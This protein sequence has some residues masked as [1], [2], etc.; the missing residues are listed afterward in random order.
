MEA[1][2]SADAKP[3]DALVFFQ[4]QTS[5]MDREALLARVAEAAAKEADAVTKLGQLTCAARGAA[6]RR[7]RAPPAPR[8]PPARRAR[9]AAAPPPAPRARARAEADHA[10]VRVRS[11]KL[12]AKEK[13]MDDL[14]AGLVAAGRAVSEAQQEAETVK[15]SVAQQEAAM[16]SKYG[17][18]IDVLKRL[19][20]VTCVARGGNART[21]HASPRMRRIRAPPP[22]SRARARR[23]SKLDVK[24][25]AMEALKAEVASSKKSAA[26][27]AAELAAVQK[28]ARAKEAELA[29]AMTAAKKT[30]MAREVELSSALAAAKGAAQKAMAA[31]A[32]A[33][34]ER[35]SDIIDVLSAKET[36]VEG[37]MTALDAIKVEREMM[38]AEGIPPEDAEE[39]A[40]KD[41][42]IKALVQDLAKENGWRGP[43]PAGVAEYSMAEVN[44][45]KKAIEKREAQLGVSRKVVGGREVVTVVSKVLPGNA[46]RYTPDELA[47]LRKAISDREKAL[48]L[49]VSAVAGDAGAAAAAV[50]G[51][52]RAQIEAL[53]S[54][55]E[56]RER[57]LGLQPVP[58]GTDASSAVGAAMDGA[59]AP[60]PV[61]TARLRAEVT[62][63]Y[64]KRELAALETEVQRL[65]SETANRGALIDSLQ[66]ELDEMLEVSGGDDKEKQE[67]AMKIA[68]RRE[69]TLSA[70]LGSVRSMYDMAKQQHAGALASRESTIEALRSDLAAT[71]KSLSAAEKEL[72]QLKRDASAAA[73]DSAAESASAKAAAEAS[74]V[75][76][77]AQVSAKEAAIEALRADLAAARRAIASAEADIVSLKKS[78]AARD[79]QLTAELNAAKLSYE[80]LKLAAAA[81]K[82]GA[83]GGKGG[84][85]GGKGGKGGAAG[86]DAAGEAALFRPGEVTAQLAAREAQV[87]SLRAELLAV[88]RAVAAAEEE[89]Q[90]RRESAAALE[91]ELTSELSA[92]KAAHEAAELAA[93]E[94]ATNAASNAQ[95][96]A[97]MMSLLSEQLSAER[98]ARRTLEAELRSAM[99]MHP[100]LPRVTFPLPPLAP[101]PKPNAG[102]GLIKGIFAGVAAGLATR[103]V[104]PAPGA[105]GAGAGKPRARA[106]AAPQQP[107][108]AAA[109]GAK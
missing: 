13:L 43:S 14:R 61:D 10:R 73:A 57:A 68:A 59:N 106:A 94:L 56:A 47:Q 11:F 44:E 17:T 5:T 25:A 40:E 100:D 1:L 87:E 12:A 102:L 51:F 85:A 38:A 84:G 24:D 18:S 103:A 82:P 26:D 3:E 41:E 46:A 30:A 66:R 104:M 92:A 20:E 95:N 67:T 79:A 35:T 36:Q 33:R 6:A 55:L 29:A 2:P 80:V 52:T 97:N 39:V 16:A 4:Q 45:L 81:G 37:L 65:R 32:A 27:A 23:S 83:D 19:G 42:L 74:R 34:A 8:A 9:S 58:M 62:S 105:G 107:A 31:A 109:A 75:A 7:V 90:S 89:A 60:G 54:A 96:A 108:A 15:K 88:R 63:T 49:A 71:R 99:E 21:P 70:E 72:S 78:A 101:P 76:H 53:R 91:S 86:A 69:Q 28:A 22:R 50:D 64:G 77:A 98:E 93:A 48:N